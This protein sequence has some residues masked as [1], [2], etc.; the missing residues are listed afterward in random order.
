MVSH[1][2]AW[3][4]QYLESLRRHAAANMS[5]SLIADAINEEFGTEYTR[6]SIISKAR[7]LG[8]TLSSGTHC[9][10]V[11]KRRKPLLEGLLR[12]IPSEVENSTGVGLLDLTDGACRFEITGST[13]VAEF[14]FCG[15]PAE[16][17]K[18]YCACHMRIAYVPPSGWRGPKPEWRK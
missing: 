18:P 13:D 11:R 1:G 7:I 15:G 6:N 9:S 5:A 16:P 14:K 12:F 10:P 17:D 8:L 3:T 4:D 2:T